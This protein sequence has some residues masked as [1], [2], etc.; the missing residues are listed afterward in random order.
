M[1]LI[2]L[3]CTFCKL[4]KSKFKELVYN[5]KLT[6]VNI[7]INHSQTS[8]IFIIIKKQLDFVL[9]KEKLNV[10]NIYVVVKKYSQLKLI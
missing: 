1:I 10:K 2:F 8:L 6:L 4:K 5:I 3:I 9:I 7:V